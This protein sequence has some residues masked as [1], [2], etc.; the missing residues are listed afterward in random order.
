MSEFFLKY[1]NSAVAEI[2]VFLTAAGCLFAILL[3][4]EFFLTDNYEKQLNDL[5]WIKK[6]K[7]L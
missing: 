4:G 3:P 6:A 2:T 7:S 1:C 5:L